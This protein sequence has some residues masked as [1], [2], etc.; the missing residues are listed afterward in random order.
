MNIW[1]QFYTDL[2]PEERQ[3]VDRVA[4]LIEASERAAPK[5]GESELGLSSAKQRRAELRARAGHRPEALETWEEF[6]A[7]FPPEERQKVDQVAQLIRAS[8][9]VALRAGE[10]EV[11]LSSAKQRRAE[12]RAR[13][14]H[15]PETLETWEDFYADLPP[16]KR[17][18][19]DRVAQ[20]IQANEGAAPRSGAAMLA[21][22][23]GKQSRAKLRARTGHRRATLKTW[24]KFYAD[25]PPEERQKVDLAMA[26]LV[27]DQ[28]TPDEKLQSIMTCLRVNHHA[29]ALMGVK[30]KLIEAPKKRGPKPQKID[31]LFV[32]D[33]KFEANIARVRALYGVSRST[34]CR[35][36]RNWRLER[37]YQK[38][39]E[40]SLINS[41]NSEPEYY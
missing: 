27:F 30:L 8:E 10:S 41:E 37:R 2:R 28:G 7:N 19:V 36:F 12:L 35:M 26:L 5:T 13:A 22:S 34:A 14:G 20:L 16:E 6:Y 18:K 17:Q 33:R 31:E 3:K 11:G 21:P 32:P 40:R 38:A 25:L 1:E 4:Q 23:S 29:A 9:G 39:R 24:E 15:R